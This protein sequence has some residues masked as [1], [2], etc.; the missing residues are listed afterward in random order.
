MKSPWI[1]KSTQRW[2]LGYGSIQI[3]LLPGQLRAFT[4]LQGENRS[5]RES[6]PTCSQDNLPAHSHPGLYPGS[7]PAP[8]TSC[9]RSQQKPALSSH[10]IPLPWL[11]KGMSPCPAASLFPQW[12]GMLLKETLPRLQMQSSTTTCSTSK[13]EHNTF[14]KSCL[15]LGI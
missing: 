14:Q 6:C 7:P 15:G 9:P 2:F 1:D 3:L 11:R 12:T 5:K 13:T 4:L 10:T 8:W